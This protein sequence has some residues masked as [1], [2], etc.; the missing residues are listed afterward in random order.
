MFTPQGPELHRNMCKQQEPLLLLD[1]STL[2]GPQLY[3]DVS[4]QHGHVLHL[5]VSTRQGPELHLDVALQ[6]GPEL[7]PWTCL[8]YRGLCCTWTCLT[9]QV[10]ELHPHLS[11]HQKP[12]MLLDVSTL[13]GLRCTW[14]CLPTL[15]MPVLHMGV[16]TPQEPKLYLDSRLHDFEKKPF[17]ILNVILVT[18]QYKK[19]T[20]THGRELC[21]VFTWVS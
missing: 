12:M 17:S 6:Q 1:M 2:Q 13:Q 5:Y 19:L 4:K 14:T 3:Q 16:P 20:L 11:W 18:L 8:L 15:Q 21:T 10:R 9:Q 7:H